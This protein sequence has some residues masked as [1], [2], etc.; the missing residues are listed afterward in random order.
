M[1]KVIGLVEP[2]VA[3][4]KRRESLLTPCSRVKMQLGW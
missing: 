1:L 4:G 2:L 3:L